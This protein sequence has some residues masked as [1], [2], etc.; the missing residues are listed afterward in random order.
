MI[1]SA[2]L[3]I[4]LMIS[5]LIVIVCATLLSI[6]YVHRLFYLGIE[7][8]ERLTQNFTAAITLLLNEAFKSDTSFKLSLYEGLN[9]TVYL[10]KDHWGIYELAIISSRIGNDSL[11]KAFLLGFKSR[12]SLKALFLADEDRPLT[13]TGKSL[14][15]GTA[16]LPKS[17]IKVGYVE[18]R[19]YEGTTLVHGLKRTSTSTLKEPEPGLISRIR[20]FIATS[21]NTS[22]PIVFPVDTGLSNSF[23]ENS[24]KYSCDGTSSNLSGKKISGHVIVSSDS[25]LVVDRSTSLNQVI[26]IAAVVKIADHFKG[27]L[28]VFATDSIQVGKSVK[29]EYPSALILLKADTAKFQPRIIIGSQS[30]IEGQVFAW[31]KAKSLLQPVIF[32]AKD[33]KIIGEIYCKGYVAPEQG[34]EINGLVSTIR[35]MAK[36]SS[37]LYENYLIDVKVDRTQLSPYYLSPTLLRDSLTKRKILCRLK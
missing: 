6:S 3:Y 17:G 35:F 19:S 20:K 30:I 11:K 27:N 33:A 13:I 10:Q 15:R 31:E 12:D 37:S 28:Q 24:L 32:L 21:K 36:R 18:G 26:L 4:S 29:L 9:D 14:I 1:R 8:K 22:V 7:R 23:F 25:V 16:Y 5:L 34:V 2:S